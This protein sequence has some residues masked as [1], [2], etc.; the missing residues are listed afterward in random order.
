M[1]IMKAMVFPGVL[2]GCETWTKTKT[3]EKKIDACNVDLEKDAEGGVDREENERGDTAGD[4]GNERRL[5]IVT[6]NHKTEDDD[7]RARDEGDDGG[8]RRR[9]E[10]ERTVEEHIDEGDAGGSGDEPGGAERSVEE[11]KVM[12]DADY[13]T[14]AK[15]HRINST[16][17]YMITGIDAFSQIL[18][19]CLV[20]FSAISLTGYVSSV[21]F[22][23]Q[24]MIYYHIVFHHTLIPAHPI[25]DTFCGI[26]TTAYLVFI[27]IFITDS[28]LSVIIITG[29][30]CR[31]VKYIKVSRQ[32]H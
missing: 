29:S 22:W 30:I 2:Y 23:L 10:E 11:K 14:V 28:L 18:S 16:R 31:K 15:I 27:L 32:F 7:L 5:V 19:I 12:E 8:M 6:E 17:C 24:F 26:L 9:E 25:S 13:M 21:I 20:I 3:M 4:R 1:R